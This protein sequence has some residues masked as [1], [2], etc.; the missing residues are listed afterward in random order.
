[1]ITGL[2]HVAV[3]VP[4]LRHAIEKFQ[5]DLGLVCEGIEEVAAAKTDVAF[6]APSNAR[7]ELIQPRKNDG[8]VARFLAAKGGGLHHLCFRSD[9]LDNDVSKLRQKGYEFLTD[10]PQTGANRTRI[11]FRTPS[12][13]LM[14]S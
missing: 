12:I 4:D 6:F 14:A 1:M 2:D 10:H 11:I 3:A 5:H 13:F 8:P 7:V 9:D